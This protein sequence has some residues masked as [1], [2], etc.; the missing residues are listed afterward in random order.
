MGRLKKY[1][2]RIPRKHERMNRKKFSK[3]TVEAVSANGGLSNLD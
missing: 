2:I 1:L 3:G